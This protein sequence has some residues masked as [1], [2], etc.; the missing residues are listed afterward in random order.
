MYFKLFDW[1]RF[2]S[3]KLQQS[4]SGCHRIILEVNVIISFIRRIMQIF[5]SALLVFWR[6]G[7]TAIIFIYLLDEDTSLLVLVPAGIGAIIEVRLS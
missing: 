2:W 3:I 7:S 4:Q 5:L 1:T 6:C